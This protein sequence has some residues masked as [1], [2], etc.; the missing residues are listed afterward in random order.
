ML[1][2]CI[3]AAG[4][5]LGPAALCDFAMAAGEPP[6]VLAGGQAG[7]RL[8]ADAA[9]LYDLDSRQVLVDKR[10]F[11]SMAPASTTKILTCLVVLENASLD[12]IVEVT[13]NAARVS[14]ARIGI[15]AGQRITVEELLYGL[16]LHSGNDAAIA[17]AE[18]V[19]GSVSGFA[20]LMN[21]RA[22]QLGALATNFVNPHGLTA[23]GHRTT[24]LDLAIIAAA[25][26]EHPQFRE[27]VSCREREIGS[28][29][30]AWTKLVR[31]TNQL[32]WSYEG[33]DGIKTGTTREA[34]LCLVA[35]ATREGRRLVAVVL[36]SGD[37][38]GDGARLLSHGFESTALTVLGRQGEVALAISV[39]DP[40]A[41][42]WWRAPVYVPLK[43]RFGR[44]LAYAAP[45]PEQPR[46]EV[47]YS[48]ADELTL[49]VGAGQVVGVALAHH[50]GRLVASVPLVVAEA[51]P[52]GVL[53][54]AGSALLGRVARWFL[55][56][57]LR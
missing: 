1:L 53:Y 56:Q 40:V 17:L 4:P 34:G 18:H 52:Q 19:G 25:A 44:T 22:R 54:A 48:I 32:L 15:R 35:S 24:A 13:P 50:E 42:F 55:Q 43:L 46:L 57:G 8:S 28:L 21:A 51:V 47:T 41:P 45:G 10:A 38:W 14:G 12:E 5:A 33:A 36:H 16:M 31:N 29:D 7:P 9:V 3:L 20:E 2:T 30:P 23:P 27:L 49:P 39:R 6:T 11:V 26:L 37:R